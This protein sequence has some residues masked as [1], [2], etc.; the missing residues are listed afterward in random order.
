DGLPPPLHAGTDTDGPLA[1]TP[2]E[3]AP[4]IAPETLADP[5]AWEMPRVM[6]LPARQTP[7]SIALA[8]GDVLGQA[9]ELVTADDYVREARS[10]G[11]PPESPEA[12]VQVLPDLNVALVVG[13]EL[14]EARGRQRGTAS[15][16]V[17]VSY[18]EGQSGALLLEEIHPTAG[19]RLEPEI[20]ERI[21][22]ELR[23]TLAVVPRP[24][25]DAGAP[26]AEAPPAPVA[27]VSASPSQPLVAGAAVHIG[28]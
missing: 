24:A 12:F 13:A 23:L 2:P 22:S 25:G 17:S 5:D 10:R 3:T 8:L 9:A 21:L 14:V 1:A 20:V 4:E 11:L 18:R 6:L 15:R 16:W 26:S 27:A 28:L 7:R 19:D